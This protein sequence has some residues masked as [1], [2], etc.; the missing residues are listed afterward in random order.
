[1][2]PPLVLEL[3]AKAGEL[4][5]EL[6]KVKGEVSK[7][8]KETDG[9]SSKMQHAFQTTAVAGK[10]ITF[11]VV[12]AGGAIAGFSLEAGAAA[13]VVDAK[14]KTAVQNAGGSMEE[15]EPKVAGLDSTM[16]GYGFTND[17][18][19][20][21]LATLTMSLKDPEKAMSVMG[22]AADLA[23]AKNMDLNAAALLVAKGMEG[24]TKPLKALGI[25]MPI[26]A[27]NAQAVR[28][29]QDALAKAQDN[30]NA[31]LA[32]TPG[33]ADS[34]SKAHGAYE[35]AVAASQLAQEKLTEKQGAGD[36]ILKTLSDRVKGSAD[37]F[38]DTFA[39]K[40]AQAKAGVEAMGEKLGGMLIPIVE[41]V[42]TVGSQWADYL[43]QNRPL[44]YTIAG[45]IGGVL[46]IAIGA[47]TVSMIAAAVATIAATWPILLIIVGIGLLVAAILWLVANWDQVTS[48][49]QTTWQAVAGFFVSVGDG[50]ASWWNGLWS[51]IGQFASDTWNGLVGFAHDSFNNLWLGLRIIGDGISSWWSGLWRGFGGMV[52]DGFNG[53]VGFV[54]GIFNNVIDVVNG[55]L[56]PINGILSA[57]SV[58]GIHLALPTLPHFDIG[59]DRVPGADGTPVPAVIHG[60][61]AV[62]STDMLA[63]RKAM[64]SR[65]T[66]AVNAQQGQQGATAAPATRSQTVQVF[67]QTNADPHR[68]GAEVGWVLR[69]LG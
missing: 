40:L 52:G 20:T 59:T 62:L 10:A 61:E 11:G 7:M 44:L 56:G 22:V 33:A 14:L 16:R 30:V 38:G 34:A 5:S 39:G 2:F 8:E 63:G 3:R 36:E 4:Y 35:K 46:V 53:V 26:Y 69:G 65:V 32:K 47:Y 17:Q 43:D 15:L 6:G 1:M 13:E 68:I 54:K 48:F 18:T 24:Q 58:I 37:A 31:I 67:A 25:D 41:K 55:L 27:G 23:K 60:G 12:A 49:L 51:G 57:G 9:S 19:N 64:P 45:I 28:L 66:A 29:A 21:A 50:I 42:I